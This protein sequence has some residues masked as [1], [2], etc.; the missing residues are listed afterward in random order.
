MSSAGFTVEILGLEEIR[1]SFNSGE[2]V[3]KLKPA[4]GLAVR[5]VHNVIASE[6][7]KR[8]N[9]S[10]ELSGVMLG[11][12]TISDVS[13]ANTILSSSLQYK[14]VPLNLAQF[15]TEETKVVTRTTA[16]FKG[17]DKVLHQ[18]NWAM[19]VNAAILRGESK[20]VMGLRSYN[21]RGAFLLKG[22]HP[23]KVAIRTTAATWNEPL[24]VSLTRAPYKQLY[25]P[26]LAEMASN[27]YYSAPVQAEIAKLESTIID[28]FIV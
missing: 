12:R 7:K 16:W 23:W 24:S 5:R 28:G 9:T 3:K 14:H 11:G 19:Q 26:S 15:V 25:G 13:Y 27:V 22:R 18:K 21:S 2:L 1:N 6:V 8:Y 4:F 17:N 10:K 20:P